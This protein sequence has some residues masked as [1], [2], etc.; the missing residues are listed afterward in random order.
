[1]SMNTTTVTRP[2]LDRLSEAF[3]N[4]KD[5]EH[6][7][8]AL[9]ESLDALAA[10]MRAATD[11]K[12]IAALLKSKGKAEAEL[13]ATRNALD[14]LRAHLLEVKKDT[15]TLRVEAVEAV[16]A[17][18][19]ADYDRVRVEV[20]E[21]VRGLRDALDRAHAVMQAAAREFDGPAR[22]GVNV[23]R[24]PFQRD[25]NYFKAIATALKLPLDSLTAGVPVAVEVGATN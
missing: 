12:V 7:E 8:T 5:H 9:V 23:P 3:N 19:R 1:M 6:R 15:T 4:V 11:P 10:D 25:A 20:A 2:A 16:E 13:T 22:Y 18:H 21:A 14:V 17:N 24:R